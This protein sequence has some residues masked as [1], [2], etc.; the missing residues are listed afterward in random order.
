MAGAT[1]YSSRDLRRSF[2]VSLC[3]VCEQ[4]VPHVGCGERGACVVYPITI[5]S[6]LSVSHLVCDACLSPVARRD[7]ARHSF[8]RLWELDILSDPLIAA[9]RVARACHR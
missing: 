6:A 3:L 5:P 7:L 1:D 2:L 4:G 9:A 8:I